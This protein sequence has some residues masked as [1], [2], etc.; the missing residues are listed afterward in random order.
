M[1]TGSGANAGKTNKSERPG[2]GSAPTDFPV[3]PAEE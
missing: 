3:V 1:D 2:P